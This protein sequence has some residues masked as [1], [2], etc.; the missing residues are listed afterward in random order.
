MSRHG[1]RFFGRNQILCCTPRN[2]CLE[3]LKKVY[4]QYTQYPK[5][6]GAAPEMIHAQKSGG[7]MSMMSHSHPRA[8]EW[9]DSVWSERQEKHGACVAYAAQT[10]GVFLSPKIASVCVCV[11]VPQV[12]TGLDMSI[13]NMSVSVNLWIF[14]MFQGHPF[15]MSTFERC[16]PQNPMVHS[17]IEEKHSVFGQTN[18]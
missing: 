11:R 12:W 2:G 7:T 1:F 15:F 5:F 10:T 8:M 6:V 13:L 18:L 16:V 4:S 3:N 9:I 14:H 17:H